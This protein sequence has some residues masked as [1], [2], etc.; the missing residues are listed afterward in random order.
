MPTIA[1]DSL[2]LPFPVLWLPFRPLALNAEAC[3]DSLGLQFLPPGCLPGSTYLIRKLAFLADVKSKRNSLLSESDRREF[4]VDGYMLGTPGEAVAYADPA[5]KASSRN[6]D[7]AA[8]SN[9]L[10]WFLKI[11]SKRKLRRLKFGE[12]K[13]VRTGQFR[14]KWNKIQ[15]DFLIRK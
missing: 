11:I 5:L 13:S 12:P 6:C 8:T 2:E 3:I 1:P 10:K 7:V 9:V 15:K 14:M 4:S